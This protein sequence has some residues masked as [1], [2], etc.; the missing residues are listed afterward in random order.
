MSQLRITTRYA[1]VLLDL[2]VQR[3]YIEM[4]DAQDAES[5]AEETWIYYPHDGL[6]EDLMMWLE[7]MKLCGVIQDYD[8]DKTYHRP[9]TKPCSN[10]AA[11]GIDAFEQQR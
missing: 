9:I 10:E 4:K 5:N 11:K 8:L 2:L 6:L 1:Q 7:L 3:S